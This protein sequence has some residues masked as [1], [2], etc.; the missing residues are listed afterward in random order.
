MNFII[1]ISILICRN[2]TCKTFEDRSTD[3]NF[4]AKISFEKEFFISMIMKFH[5][6]LKCY[7]LDLNVMICSNEGL[8]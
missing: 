7:I 4:K 6:L 1:S 2:R 5:V 3:K 8:W